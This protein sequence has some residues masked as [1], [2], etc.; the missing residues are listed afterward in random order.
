M[1]YQGYLVKVGDYK[2]PHKYIKANSYSATLIVQ[3]LDSF[4]DMDG[5]LHRTAL[6]HRVNKVEFETPAML[7]DTQ[8]TDFLSNIQANYTNEAQRK[9]SATIYVPEINDYMTQDF[10][11][12]DPQFSIY[13]IKNNVIRYNSVRFG[14]IAY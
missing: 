8:M 9:V 3:D 13:M 14:L 2:I 10:Y 6:S 1:S 12:P 4:R 5:V 7:T 11:F